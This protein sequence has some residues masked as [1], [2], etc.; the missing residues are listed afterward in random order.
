MVILRLF[1]FIFTF[2]APAFAIYR[3]EK[4]KAQVI[5]DQ[6]N[7]KNIIDK[8][9]KDVTNLGKK[10]EN[11]ERLLICINDK[12]SRLKWNN[13]VVFGKNFKQCLNWNFQGNTHKSSMQ[14][15]QKFKM[16]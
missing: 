15:E 10:V 11:M 6:D 13:S 7:S 5:I 8:L 16:L 1:A 2:F 14:T 9:Q 12:I 4:L 3:A